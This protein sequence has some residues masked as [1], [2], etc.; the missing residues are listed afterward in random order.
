MFSAPEKVP[1]SLA[2]GYIV[3]VLSVPRIK[4]PNAVIVGKYTI[5]GKWHTAAG[6]TRL[7][8]ADVLIAAP[9]PLKEFAGTDKSSLTMLPI[10]DETS[11]NVQ[12]VLMPSMVVTVGVNVIGCTVTA[13]AFFGLIT[14]T[15]IFGV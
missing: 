3:I 4:E 14:S 13:G 9:P 10:W 6:A 15:C 11:S 7:D 1:V 2:A 8:T 5:I 12:F